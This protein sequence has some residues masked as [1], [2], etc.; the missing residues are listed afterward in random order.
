MWP[1]LRSPP[2]N[3]PTH[4]QDPHANQQDIPE[5]ARLEHIDLSGNQL[6][7]IAEL[8]FLPRLK[9]LDASSN[10]ITS[11][12][13]LRL[14]NLLVLNLS[15]ND[16]EAVP[17][18]LAHFPKLETLDL[19]HNRIVPPLAPLTDAPKLQVLDLSYNKLRWKSKG[20]F[21]RDCKQAMAPL[22]RLRDLRVASNPF[23]LDDATYKEYKAYFLRFLMPAWSERLRNPIQRMN[24]A[25]VNGSIDNEP[26]SSD[27]VS[28]AKDLQLGE[29]LDDEGAGVTFATGARADAD[30]AGGE[31]GR[32]RGSSLGPDGDGA[33]SDSSMPGA[34]QERLLP[35]ADI[36]TL[37]PDMVPSLK[38]LQDHAEAARLEPMQS[39]AHVQELVKDV[40]LLHAQLEKFPD[41]YYLY[42]CPETGTPASR[43]VHAQL[44]IE[45][46]LDS[47]VLLAERLPGV[48]D[49]VLIVIATLASVQNVGDAGADGVSTLSAA[50]MVH[51]QDYITASEVTREAALRAV[52]Q[53]LLP[54]LRHRDKDR[55]LIRSITSLARES[56]CPEM[57]RPFSRKIAKWM[58]P[59]HV[60]SGAGEG[61]TG[62]NDDVCAMAA[63]ASADKEA[64]VLLGQDGLAQ[65]VQVQFAKQDRDLW[66][67]SLGSSGHFI[68]LLKIM[69]NLSSWRA[70]FSRSEPGTAAMF[71]V[72][73][74]V[75]VQL[76]HFL[77]DFVRRGDVKT[78]SIVELIGALIDTL[79]G[80]SKSPE[81][82]RVLVAHDSSYLVRL[83]DLARR[84]Q[85]H[86]IITTAV[87]KAVYIVL[88]AD[89]VLFPPAQNTGLPVDHIEEIS[90]QLGN[91]TPLLDYLNVISD[92]GKYLEACKMSSETDMLAAPRFKVQTDPVIHS[93]LI[94]VLDIV[95]FYC[96]EANKGKNQTAVAVARD[97]NENKREA[98]LFD[99]LNTPNEHVK[100]AVIA[101]LQEVPLAE[102]DSSEVKHLVDDLNGQTNLSG[103]QV[104]VEII[105]G[106]FALL[107]RLCLADQVSTS[108]D[109]RN[110]F[111]TTTV[112]AALAILARNE[113]R[114]TR[115]QAKETVQKAKLSRE[116]V[117]FLLA[118]SVFPELRSCLT[119]RNSLEEVSRIL[120]DEDK[121]SAPSAAQLTTARQLT[122]DAVEAA[123]QHYPV[124]VETT[125]AGRH[126]EYLLKTLWAC[127]PNGVVAPRLVRRLADICAGLRDPTID[128]VGMVSNLRRGVFGTDS[129]LASHGSSGDVEEDRSAVGK[130]GAN[131]PSSTNGTAIPEARD[132][133]EEKDEDIPF[134]RIRGEPP[135]AAIIES[136]GGEGGHRDILRALINTSVDWRELAQ[137]AAARERSIDLAWLGQ[138]PNPGRVAPHVKQHVLVQHELLFQSQGL[139]HLLLYLADAVDGAVLI[140]G[141]LDVSRRVDDMLAELEK[142]RAAHGML[143]SGT[144]DGQGKLLQHDEGNGLAKQHRTQEEPLSELLR[145]TFMEIGSASVSP[146]VGEQSAAQSSTGLPESSPQTAASD[147]AAGRP[148]ASTVA[149]GRGEG[150]ASS[151][152]VSLR[153]SKAGSKDADARVIAMDPDAADD[154][155]ENSSI[156]LLAACLRLT[157][158]TLVT[159]TLHTRGQAR[160]LLRRPQELRRLANICMG[161]T[162]EPMY[163]IANI[164]AKFF[165]V[166][167]EVCRIPST[168]RQ[169]AIEDVLP[170]YLI[171]SW[172]ASRVLNVVR[173]RLQKHTRMG[174]VDL[175]LTLHALRA[176]DCIT[177]QAD[178]LAVAG[179][180]Q[181]PSSSAESLSDLMAAVRLQVVQALV[182][183][184]TLGA[185]FAF[186]V[187]EM[188]RSRGGLAPDDARSASG[189][190]GGRSGGEAGHVGGSARAAGS[191]A[192]S[193]AY[194]ADRTIQFALSV[195]ATCLRSVPDYRYTILEELVRSDVVDRYPIR[196]SVVQEL[197]SQVAHDT[198]RAN[199]QAYMQRTGAFNPEIRGALP[200]DG[201]H[202]KS[203]LPADAGTNGVGGGGGAGSGEGGLFAWCVGLGRGGSAD[204]ARHNVDTK[205][206]RA[207]TG[208][209]K[210]GN[211]SGDADLGPAEDLPA[212][213]WAVEPPPAPAAKPS[214][215]AGS[216][217]SAH[218]HGWEVD[219]VGVER[220]VEKAWVECY[221]PDGVA[222]CLLV[223]TSEAYYLMQGRHRG[224]PSS[225]T[226]DP[227]EFTLSE[228]SLALAD[229]ALRPGAPGGPSVLYRR[230]YRAMERICL[231]ANS[232]RLHVV[233]R[234]SD[235]QGDN[236][237]ELTTFIMRGRRQ[238]PSVFA[239]FVELC[240]AW[241]AIDAA[242]GA[243]SRAPCVPEP[244]AALR[245]AVLHALS[246]GDAV[247]RRVLESKV[248][249]DVH[250]ALVDE[251]LFSNS[252]H[253]AMARR[254]LILTDAEL[255]VCEVNWRGW[256]F[257]ADFDAERARVRDV[258]SGNGGA[259]LGG[260][261]LEQIERAEAAIFRA[262]Q[263]QFKRWRSMLNPVHTM[264]LKDLNVAIFEGTDFPL[265][266]LGFGT[267]AVGGSGGP[268]AASPTADSGAS[269]AASFDFA[270]RRSLEACMIVVQDDWTRELWRRK[271]TPFLQ[272][273]RGGVPDDSI[274]VGS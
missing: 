265:M 10:C 205:A 196:P 105:A 245:E 98:L 17:L 36:S 188:D 119:S 66:V 32:P 21:L 107:T 14:P 142:L 182:P 64:A 3:P 38:R 67:R 178:H 49:Q 239:S 109:F 104:E 185:I 243:P 172:S 112:S 215:R 8:S 217:S 242:L 176:L 139:E 72:E 80:L 262:E 255:C 231:A 59:R 130:A 124:L 212:T 136:L 198:Y 116:C 48:L 148:L 128:E 145:E 68:S 25:M 260:D 27:L 259:A 160:D 194:G 71:F 53:T 69:E 271:L 272:K 152:V 201:V 103:G 149:S 135:Q 77:N 168:R 270:R 157:H 200:A 171:V 101:C 269:L 151:A 126:V 57:L 206:M 39:T 41:T 227:R 37:S 221:T 249:G 216:S 122:L 5:L 225:F 175:A 118:C 266:V 167:T 76:L 123:Q 238:A 222:L 111:G 16:L 251:A 159:G 273:L 86:P 47:V 23:I 274:R 234:P 246:R 174:R 87:L 163:H 62:P 202:F 180:L 218:L 15:K 229:A 232:Q 83:F 45:E 88:C 110:R 90:K 233:H 137:D 263:A 183:I 4:Q 91:V 134:G 214:A 115:G 228:K 102:L 211:G 210:E 28:R 132:D 187:A 230:R 189:A 153:K 81:G 247:K 70:P 253:G 256:D 100:L 220:V 1:L 248:G 161:S 179:A 133:E 42:I 93:L 138:A 79:A 11:I 204:P 52:E 84:S 97:L 125:A 181:G 120:K 43:D 177:R 237:P 89:P 226:S 117:R 146:R 207:P 267:P 13:G 26:V 24:I 6:R 154:R 244:D 18:G 31:A 250:G 46:F 173:Q 61:I 121:H 236:V 114:N 156:D 34:D 203:E 141:G 73:K 144:R 162:A 12:D 50:C 33:D 113:R 264:A 209:P 19:S 96:A 240:G 252:A 158:T 143:V 75:H 55:E 213:V 140:D 35:L 106:S 30:A 60:T 78:R 74:G 166:C 257:A 44:A 58:Q 51:L 65:A 190:R 192:G 129:G 195:I 241:G 2:P 170:L 268:G 94:S 223:L 169:E 150:G 95:R 99:C 82:L 224:C 261:A 85:V 40:R 22:S 127:A 56:E 258:V 235:V 199:L 197:L 164:G 54:R 155:P 191:A 147:D 184:S 9:R 108:N 29:M 186:L 131:Q 165:A 7:S 20:A 92:S 208:T 63:V 254:V 193:G 219:R